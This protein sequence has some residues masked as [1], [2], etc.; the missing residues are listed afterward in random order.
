MNGTPEA[1]HD[2]PHKKAEECEGK[3]KRDHET[4]PE[5]GPATIH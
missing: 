4:I 2:K 5:P 1:V 3:A